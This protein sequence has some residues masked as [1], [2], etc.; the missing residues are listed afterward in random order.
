MAEIVAPLAVE[1]TENVDAAENW[2]VGI[3]LIGPGS[4]I[5]MREAPLVYDCPIP[6]MV[7]ALLADVFRT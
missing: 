1:L 5:P 3:A 6:N 2:S 4:G 7:K